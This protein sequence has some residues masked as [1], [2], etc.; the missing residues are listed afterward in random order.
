MRQYSNIDVTQIE[1]YEKKI[2][3]LASL[4]KTL[5][6]A[7]PDLM[8]VLS[9]NGTI[10]N[11]KAEDR[12][13]LYV[14]PDTFLGKNIKDCLPADVARLAI[15]KIEE[16]LSTGQISP[17]TYSLTVDNKVHFYEC[18]MSYDG[19]DEFIALVRDFTEQK[20]IENELLKKDRLLEAISKVSQLLLHEKPLSE[21]I[22]EAFGILVE[23]IN[24]D[25]V[26]IFQFFDDPVTS[27][28]QLLSRYQYTREGIESITSIVNNDEQK[29]I[30]APFGWYDRLLKGDP[31]IG[32]KDAFNETDRVILDKFHS[33]STAIFPI[34]IDNRCWGFVGFDNCSGDEDLSEGEI[35]ILRSAISSIGMTILR[36]F[37]KDELIKAK[38]ATEESE[39]FAKT[40]IE[41]SPIGIMV[42]DSDG[43]CKS[44]NNAWEEMFSISASSAI[45]KINL[46]TT[47]TGLAKY[48]PELKRSLRGETVYQN[49]LIL[50]T[51]DNRGIN[52]RIYFD[53]ISFPFIVHESVS[54]IAIIVQE[55][56]KFVHFEEELQN[57]NSE[58]KKM[59]H[60]LKESYNIVEIA[61]INSEKSESKLKTILDNSFNLIAHFDLDGKIIYC[62]NS[63]LEV[64]GYDPQ[65]L[66]SKN[67]FS[68]FHPEER[69]KAKTVIFKSLIASGTGN[70]E[71]R[72]LT[73]DGYYRLI[74][75]R[76][77]LFKGDK[78]KKDTILMS[79]QDISDRKRTEMILKVQ[80]NLAYAIITCKN[81]NDFYSVI[82]REINSIMEVNNLYV[83]FY[84]EQT[85][86]FRLEGIIDEKDTIEEWDS[87]G[88]LTGYMF[89]FG[90]PCIFYKDDILKLHEE[91]EIIVI[92]SMAEVWLGA[93][94]IRAGKTFGA[95]VIQNYD[96]P[97]AFYRSDLEIIEI[98]ANE[99][100]IFIEKLEAEESMRKLTTAII[101]SPAS[102]VI[103]DKNGNIEFVNPKF[104]ELTGYSYEETIGENPRILKSGKQ[105]DEVFCDLWQTISSGKEWRGELQNKKKNGDFYWEDISISPIFNENGK[106]VN[107][108][109]VKEDITDRKKL[110][111][112]LIEAKE[113]AEES[114]RLKTAF[115]QNISHE[116]RTPMNGILGF[117]ELLQEPD[118]SGEEQKEYIEIIEKSGNRML[119][120]INDIINVSKIEAGIVSLQ[121]SKVDIVQIVNDVANFFR[122]E[123]EKKGMKI[124]TDM[125][126]FE[127]N[128]TIESDFDK[129]FAIFTNLVKNAIKYSIEGTITVG[130]IKR[131]TIV[132]C[133]VKD[134]GIG[135]PTERQSTVFERFTQADMNS[136][137][138]SEGAGLGLSI[139]KGY[140]NLLGGRIY[141]QS[142]PGIGSKFTFELPL[143]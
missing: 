85:G 102:V 112:D 87:E 67:I 95:I 42:I 65:E 2:D 97:N 79:S 105:S 137:R 69:E 124:I 120:T 64:L 19:K 139:V 43:L 23:V 89:R 100:T 86:R 113:R 66:I 29:P 111:T 55:V 51:K 62:N 8:F 132:E 50:D 12:S 33:V 138:S 81:F 91:G 106:I 6:G 101:Q 142:E 94:I 30:K 40:L 126:H 1:E 80:R 4:N 5:I 72:V 122:P 28:V 107:Y 136:K 61:R 60:E 21:I 127:K 108:V 143:K 141:L 38:K 57:Q 118:T 36:E 116:I 53:C 83:A 117:I 75:H 110:I 98:I 13:L 121:L 17:F 131:D 24:R 26:Y 9:R 20:K 130:F 114:D 3:L 68:L 37:R 71:C 34:L 54:R 45:N 16:I 135:I 77:R 88:S 103:T 129:V 128:T 115:L 78:I 59:A 44:V 10:I 35:S 48:A 104:S 99:I 39:M 92:G 27:E 73:K 18:R 140:I 90:K 49:H 134:T 32:R 15:E 70:V 52:R 7:I 14:Q 109:G 11:Y 63:Y 96:N 25:R 123:I 74:D 31:I 76:F 93:P 41:T 82:E 84:N 47:E 22:N 125:P 119:T 46:F 58:L 133:F 56:T